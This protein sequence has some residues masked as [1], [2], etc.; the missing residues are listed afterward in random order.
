M[1]ERDE[2]EG[3]EE[4]ISLVRGSSDAQG[5][6]FSGGSKLSGQELEGSCGEEEKAVCADGFSENSMGKEW[7]ETHQGKFVWWRTSLGLRG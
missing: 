3:W 5:S 1:W 6:S 2:K 7:P 4:A